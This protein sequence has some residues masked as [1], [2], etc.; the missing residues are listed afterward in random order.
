MEQLFYWLIGTT[1]A[2]VGTVFTIK[3]LFSDRK[4]TV[5]QLARDTKKDADD[6]AERLSQENERKAIAVRQD[7]RDHVSSV[8]Q[9]LRQDI[10]LQ[11]SRIFSKIDNLDWRQQQNKISLAEHIQNERDENARMMKSIEFLQTMAWG[12]DAKSVPDYMFGREESQEHKD[13]P[14]KGA[15]KDRPEGGKEEEK[16]TAENEERIKEE[17][18]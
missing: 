16:Q 6:L 5:L 7:M 14:T 3:F 1:I 18:K 15:F 17:D 11:S 8:I 4:Y 10:E 9:T 12:P 2:I 13:E